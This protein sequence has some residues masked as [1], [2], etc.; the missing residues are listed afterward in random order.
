MVHPDGTSVHHEVLVACSPV[1]VLRVSPKLR[2][3]VMGKFADG[4][5]TV[6]GFG[7]C[8]TTHSGAK[9]MR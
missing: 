7:I 5:N 4:E 1:H 3:E 8:S 9:E 6:L 2:V